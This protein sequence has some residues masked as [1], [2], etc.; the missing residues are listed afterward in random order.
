MPDLLA[1]CASNSADH[2]EVVLSALGSQG[3]S[4]ASFWSNSHT[5]RIPHGHG[6]TLGSPE[7]SDEHLSAVRNLLSRRPEGQTTVITDSWSALDLS[8]LGF[9]VLFTDPWLYRP[10][11]PP[12]VIPRP[13]GLLIERVTAADDLAQ[14]EAASCDGF[15]SPDISVIGP[16]GFYAAALI[17][18]PRMTFFTGRVNG[19]VVAG[20]MA[21]VSDGLAAVN[22][23]FTLAEFRGRGYGAAMAWTATLA[24]PDLP[25]MTTASEMSDRIFRRMGF[26]EIG[27]RT[28]WI[29]RPRR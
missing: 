10:P 28:V 2:S 17:E 12:P 26:M 4:G 21:H 29:W 9:E 3:V 8:G 6:I 23:L 27:Q 5:F 19:R 20:A 15:G 22:T 24:R 1:P 25:A 14:F 16:H 18:T 7:Y 13:D 11:G